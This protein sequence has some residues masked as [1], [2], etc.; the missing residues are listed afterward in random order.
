MR[1]QVVSIL[2][3][4][5]KAMRRRALVEQAN[6]WL[7]NW[8]RWQVFVFYG[9]MTLFADKCL[10]GRDGQH[11]TKQGKTIFASRMTDLIRRVLDQ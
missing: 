11:L 5:G 3:A 7:Q 2:S 6:N 8:C 9:C 4:R 10:L 1:T